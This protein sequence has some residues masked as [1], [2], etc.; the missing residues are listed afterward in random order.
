MDSLTRR[1]RTILGT[2]PSAPPAH[3]IVEDIWLAVVDG[4]LETGERLPTARQLAIDLGL[5]P[6]SIERAYA[7]LERRGVVATRR[8]EGVFVALQPPPE[9]ELARRR[10]FT[11]LCRS[12][13]ERASELGFGVDD[14]MDE[15]AEYRNTGRSSSRTPPDP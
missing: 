8:G 2:D 15:I 11:S 7:E 9:A 14:L 10:E 6:R 5:S 3:R 12:A 1:L 13:V 4:S